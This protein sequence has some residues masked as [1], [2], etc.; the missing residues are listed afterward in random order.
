MLFPYKIE[1]D[2]LNTEHKFF[3][4]NTALVCVVSCCNNP[5]G[6]GAQRRGCA[7]LQ[8]SSNVETLMPFPELPGFEEIFHLYH[9]YTN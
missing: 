8:S 6:Q 3:L 2:Q 7:L 9:L 1:H 5:E 4:I